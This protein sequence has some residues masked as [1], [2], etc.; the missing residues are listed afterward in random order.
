MSTVLTF[1]TF[2][3]LHPGHLHFLKQA[4]KYG[5]KL[6][7]VVSRDCHVEQFKNRTPRL[8]EKD[9]LKMIKSLK[10]V[11]LAI[12]GDRKFNYEHLVKKIKPDIIALGY[13]QEPESTETIKQRLARYNLYPRIIR[14]KPYKPEKY[15]SSL[16][17]ER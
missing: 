15:K 7:V 9:R 1:G 14:L 5:D 4:K 12:L 16:L 17:A 8:K 13:D 2:D 3:L 10:I 6:T 11:D